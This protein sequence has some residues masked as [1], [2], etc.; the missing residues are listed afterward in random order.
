MRKD[1]SGRFEVI[2]VL[3]SCVE[4]VESSGISIMEYPAPF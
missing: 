3:G 4:W 1:R 2:G